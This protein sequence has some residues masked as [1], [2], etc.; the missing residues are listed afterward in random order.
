MTKL[1]E[2]LWNAL[3]QLT[4]D[5]FDSFKWFLKLDGVP[6]GFPRIAAARLQKANRQEAVD[7]MLQKHGGP[8]ALKVTLAVLEKI[9]RNDLAQS[10]FA[11]ALEGEC[12]REY[13]L[14]SSLTTKPTRNCTT[15]DWFVSNGGANRSRHSA[16]C[17]QLQV[18][19]LHIGANIVEH[20]ER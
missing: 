16:S 13:R 19:E 9:S 3:L 14:T 8:G 6:E 5:E 2:E 7:L 17:E 10:L 4:D 11:L 18:I 1:A 20:T 12:D 15:C